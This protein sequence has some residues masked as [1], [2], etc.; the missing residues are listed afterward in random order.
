M[1]TVKYALMLLV[2]AML[3]VPMG[4]AANP[5]EKKLP[6]KEATIVYELSGL[7]TG[8]ET[9]Y[10]KDHGQRTAEYRTTTATMF[11]MTMKNETVDITTPDWVYSFDLQERTGTKSINPQKLMI[12]EYNKLAAADKKKVDENAETM[13]LWMMEGMH[14][15]IEPNVGEL[16]GFPCDRLTMMG[17]TVYTMHGTQIPLKTVTDMMGVSMT[18]TAMFLREDP[19]D[20]VYFQFP[21][22]IEPQPDPEADQM[23]R[24]MAEQTI[25]MLKDP[26]TFKEQNKG[27]MF[28]PQGDISPED[29]QKM[30]EAMNTLKGLFGN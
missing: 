15:E 23:A 27:S 16:L 14:A 28:G 30:E 22:G 13:G 9:L 25:A 24:A 2:T 5:W 21:E 3:L 18:S 7:E 8:E 12:E 4:A 26:E 10:I 17:V 19:V 29:K 11:G 6:F 20:E 1:K